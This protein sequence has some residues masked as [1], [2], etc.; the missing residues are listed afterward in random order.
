MK[1]VIGY[2]EEDFSCLLYSIGN[3]G[4]RINAARGF[5]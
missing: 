3:Y 5:I 1:N 4:I 2:R